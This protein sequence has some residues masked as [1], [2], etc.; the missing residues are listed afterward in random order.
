MKL[1]S[2][3]VVGIAAL[4]FSACEKQPYSKLELMES[5]FQ[6]DKAAEGHKAD[7]K[8]DTKSDAKPAAAE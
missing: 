3:F 8:H 1:F 5:P 7:T 4:S 6:H 2:L